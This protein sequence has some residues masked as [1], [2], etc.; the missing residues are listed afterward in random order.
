MQAVEQARA[1]KNA[2][3]R[4]LPEHQAVFETNFTALAA[5][6]S[7]LDAALKTMSASAPDKPLLASHPVYQYFSRRYGLNL[8]TVM[9]EP[10]EPLAEDQ[11]RV[12]EDLLRHHPAKWMIWEAQPSATTV[13]RLR[14]HGVESVVLDPCSTV[15]AK[16]D[17]MEVMRAN[18]ELLRAAFL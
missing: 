1:I 6:L 2:L 4:R 7:Q 13:D 15:P 17:F 5:E 10:G 14:R 9:W 11:W 3:A 12:L 16:G 8:E 18:I